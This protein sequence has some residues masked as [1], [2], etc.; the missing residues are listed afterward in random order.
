MTKELELTD[1]QKPKVEA[2]LK[3][4]EKKNKEIMD[5]SSTS[6]EEK[7][8]KMRAAREE[9]GKKLKEILTADQYKKYEDAMARFRG[10]A[11]KGETKKDQTEKKN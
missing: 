7:R 6:F 8:P 4:T 11:K 9:E 10:G 3:E 1:A 5:D 2:V